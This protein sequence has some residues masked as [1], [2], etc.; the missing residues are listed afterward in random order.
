MEEK[1]VYIQALEAEQAGDWAKAHALVQ[2]MVT[3][4]AAWVHAYLHR[5]EGDEANAAYWYNRAVQ[6]VCTTSLNAEWRALYDELF[7]IGRK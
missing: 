1:N 4:E 6:P 2:D 5:V 7:A 3:A